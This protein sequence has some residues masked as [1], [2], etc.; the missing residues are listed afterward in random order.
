MQVEEEL[1]EYK[2]GHGCNNPVGSRS[3]KKSDAV[4]QKKTTVATNTTMLWCNDRKHNSGG[5]GVYYAHSIS[6]QLDSK[7]K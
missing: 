5:R 7:K 3:F 2:R 1:I 6:K 4:R